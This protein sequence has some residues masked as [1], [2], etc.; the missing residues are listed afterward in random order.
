MLRSPANP[1]VPRSCGAFLRLGAGLC[2]GSSVLA[3]CLV[4][5]CRGRR[6]PLADEDREARAG[7][8]TPDNALGRS[9]AR[10]ARSL[11]PSGAVICLAN[12]VRALYADAP[13]AFL[14]KLMK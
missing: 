14:S 1:R 3:G 6:G 5:R 8:W 13:S 7:R 4:L 10:M 9:S 2:V 12:A 11:R